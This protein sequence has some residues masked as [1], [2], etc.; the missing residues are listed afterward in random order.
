[1]KPS[2]ISGEYDA[3]ELTPIARIDAQDESY[4]LPLREYLETH[5]V[6]VVVNAPGDT[7]ALYHIVAGDATFVKQIISREYARGIKQLGIIL[8]GGK[9]EESF[10]GKIK[11]VLADPTPM[12]AEDVLMVFKFYFT[13]GKNQ[14]DL[15]TGHE[16]RTVHEQPQIDDARVRSLIA[17]MYK[18]EA[19]HETRAVRERKT[20][21]RHRIRTWMLGVLIAAGL[22]ILPT[23]WYLTSMMIAGVA[24]ASGA[25]ALRQGNLSTV[26]WDTRIADYWVHQGS[27]VLSAA[28][29]PLSWG[30]WEDRIRGQQRLLSFINDAIQA[31]NEAVSIAGVA[32]RVAAGLLNQVDATSTGTTAASDIAQLRLSLSTLGN[33]LGLAQAELS[34]LLGSRTF[35]FS[36]PTLSQKGNQGIKDLALI[37]QSSDDIDKLLSLFL[38]LAGFREP[39]TYLILLQNSMELRATGGFIGSLG[40]ASFEDG[41]LTNLDIQDVYTFDGQL[42]GHVDPPAPIRELLGQEHWYLRDSNWDP[43]FKESGS[44]AAWFYEKE[45]GTTVNGVVGISTPFITELLDAT[46]PIEL[47]DYRDRITKDNFYGKSIYYTQNDFFPGSTQKKDFLGSLARAMLQAITSGTNVNTVKLFRAIT[48]ALASHDLVLMVEDPELQSLIEHYGW[49]GRVPPDIGCAGTTRG[50][51]VFD[52]MIAVESNLGVNKVNYFVTRDLERGITV[53]ADGTRSEKVALTLHNGSG[54]QDKIMPYRTYV[55]FVLPT[56]STLGEVSI[57]GAPVAIRKNATSDIVPYAEMATEASGLYSL[58]V[59]LDVP[60]GGEKRLSVTYTQTNPLSFGAGGAILDVFLQ[61]QAGVS[62]EHVRTTV[63]YPIGWTAGIEEVANPAGS[64]LV[65]FI[66]KPDQLT[67]NTILVSDAITRIRFTKQ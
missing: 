54:A 49:A 28:S 44:R 8:G 60:P 4:I 53:N 56:G 37:R 27:F 40:L 42:K 50:E 66:A 62:G 47:A 20:Q 5:G 17:D 55:R 35:P 10:S 41:R 2:D 26:S 51:C 1:M 9:K 6:D 67:Y 59:A 36:I 65:D 63:T 43:D 18:E 15:R 29:I 38:S 31:E 3:D 23:I 61:K 34:L 14:L 64:Q 52:P 58:G 33:T 39:R 11:I 24:V 16:T 25:R 32:G 19:T 57:D 7:S 12:R 22:I 21:R 13:E 45:S 46:G 30:G 48:T